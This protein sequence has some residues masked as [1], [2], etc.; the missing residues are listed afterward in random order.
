MPE[1]VSHLHP[2]RLAAWTWKWWFGRGFSLFQ[3]CILRFH[4][5]LPGWIFGIIYRIY[6]DDIYIYTYIYIMIYIWM[7]WML[8]W[9]CFHFFQIIDRCSLTFR[10]RPWKL[11]LTQSLVSWLLDAQKFM[12]ALHSSD[13]HGSCNFLRNLQQDPLNGPLNLCI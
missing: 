2:R 11:P 12:Q 13:H 6:M 1:N 9:F 3:G 7:I 10:R 5:N 8:H 4:V